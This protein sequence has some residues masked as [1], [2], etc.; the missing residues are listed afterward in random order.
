M[1]SL[2][3]NYSL[4]FLAENNDSMHEIDGILINIKYL[5]KHVLLSQHFLFQGIEKEPL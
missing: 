5:T 1:K 2:E 4:I 3:S